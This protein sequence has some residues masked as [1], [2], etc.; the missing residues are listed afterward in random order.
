M[1]VTEL[2]LGEF[3]YTVGRLIEAV[4]YNLTKFK[5]VADFSSSAHFGRLVEA[6]EALQN[7]IKSTIEVHNYSEEIC[8][9]I[10]P[11]ISKLVTLCDGIRTLVANRQTPLTEAIIEETVNRLL[12]AS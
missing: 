4:E 5:I 1:S 12:S 7:S 3:Y 8:G 9:D 10:G 6:I 2:S 11:D